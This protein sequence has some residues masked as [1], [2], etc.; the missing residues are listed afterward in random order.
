MNKQKDTFASLCLQLAHRY[1]E[2]TI[3]DDFLTL[4]LC[5]LCINP[6]TGKSDDEELYMQTVAKYATDPK[7]TN[8]PSMFA[9]LVLE[10]ESLLDSSECHD[11]LGSFYEQHLFRKGTAQ[12]FTPW[13]VCVFIAR[14]LGAE[15]IEQDRQ[16]H[17]LDPSCGAG[18]MLMASAPVFGPRHEYY[19]I[20][21]DHT[22]VKMTAINLFLSGVFHG[23]VM[24]ADALRPDDFRMS[25]KL[26]FLPFGIFRIT[27]KEKSKLWH[28]HQ[29]SFVKKSSE[30]Q[31]QQDENQKLWQKLAK[32]NGVSQLK[33]F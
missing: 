8:I 21:I 15:H 30:S 29:N 33:M 3:F 16:L 17:I 11:V 12:F 20:D 25:Y 7:R 1:D 14:C 10:M 27:E 2:R 23:E 5:A 18:R 28:M 26:S 4:T 19:G 6:L 13:P 24:W 22:C 9:S 32:E 31:I